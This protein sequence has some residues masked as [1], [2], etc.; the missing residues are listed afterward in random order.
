M[1][2]DRV[3]DSAAIERKNIDMT[4][5]HWNVNSRKTK[6]AP[7]SRLRFVMK[8][9]IKSKINVTPTLFGRSAIIEAGSG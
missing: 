9:T 4:N 8:Y 3:L 6:N 7:G 2:C 1:A 5:V